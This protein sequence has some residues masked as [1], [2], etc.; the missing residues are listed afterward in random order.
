MASLAEVFK[1]SYDYNFQYKSLLPAHRAQLRQLRI[2][3]EEINRTQIFSLTISKAA[4][5]VPTLKIKDDDRHE[6]VLLISFNDQNPED[7]RLVF[8]PLA[9]KQPLYGHV[10]GYRLQKGHECENLARDIGCFL[11]EHGMK[12]DVLREANSL[13]QDTRPIF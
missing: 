12:Q 7:V 9:T 4:E 13:L 6:L 11:A 8:S 2:F 1:A 3:S 5:A 10:E